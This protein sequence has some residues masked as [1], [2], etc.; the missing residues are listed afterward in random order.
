MEQTIKILSQRIILRECEPG[1]WSEGGMG[2][3]NQ[4]K[5]EILVRGDMSED[6][7]MQTLLHETL[8]MIADMNSLEIVKEETTISVLANG[9]I[10]FMKDNPKLIHRI[11]GEET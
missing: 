11:L 1:S 9:L 8:H 4:A 6:I 5:G 7:K 10:T 3:S 2:R